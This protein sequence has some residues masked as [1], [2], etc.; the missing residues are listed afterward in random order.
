MKQALLKL[1]YCFYFGVY[2]ID[3]YHWNMYARVCVWL[4]YSVGECGASSREVKEDSAMRCVVVRCG[5]VC[6]WS[7]W[8]GAAPL[9][10]TDAK[11]YPLRG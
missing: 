5:V 9:A 1:F 2:L 10:M 3:R 11:V 7:L 8:A 4:V 6:C